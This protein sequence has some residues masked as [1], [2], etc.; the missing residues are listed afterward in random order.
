M[1]P[2]IVCNRIKTPDGTILESRF[3]HDWNEHF[4]EFSKERYFVDGGLDYLK[5]SIN[6]VP[7]VEMSLTTDSP[8]ED[9]RTI[10]RRGTFNKAGNLVWI[11]I[12]D[13]SDAHLLNAIKY[14]IEKYGNVYSVANELY[15]KELEYRRLHN[16]TISDKD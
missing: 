2:A 14:N 12:C 10:Y 3:R 16:I 1:T 6:K 4:D 5:R 15:R 7:Y 8:F 13:M 11:A 9:V